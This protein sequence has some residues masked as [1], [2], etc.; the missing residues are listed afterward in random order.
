MKR[1]FF[2]ALILAGTTALPAM[3]M[4][5]NGKM[6]ASMMPNGDVMMKVQLPPDE[7]YAIDRSMKNNHM[8]CR[9]EDFPG[10]QYTKI[11]ECGPNT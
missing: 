4:E 2:A 10:Q 5:T 6:N 7:Y 9:L 11:L 8:H 1:A 3:A